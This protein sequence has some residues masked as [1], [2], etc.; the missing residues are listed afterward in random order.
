MINHKCFEIIYFK[1]SNGKQ[2]VKDWIWK[3]REAQRLLVESDL[4]YASNFWNESVKKKLVRKIQGR[5]DIWE[6]RTSL[7]DGINAR[8]FFTIDESGETPTMVLLHSFFKKTQKIPRKD[9][10][11]AA[12]RKKQ[13]FNN[14][15]GNPN[16]KK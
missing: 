6:V 4:L 14:I 9:L 1:T 16:V 7:P 3:L 5:K 2:P 13:Y 10:E 11:L 15:G 12:R 8:I